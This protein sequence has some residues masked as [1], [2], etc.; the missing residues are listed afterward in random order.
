MLL[1]VW[2]C[3]AKSTADRCDYNQERKE[4][5]CIDICYLRKAC[6]ENTT[7][8]TVGFTTYC[9]CM[10]GF[11]GDP[12]LGCFKMDEKSPCSPDPCGSNANCIE[13]DL[14]IG[15]HCKCKTGFY[16]WPPNCREGCSSD[17]ECGQTEVCD[18]NN[19]CVELC[20][21]WRCGDNSICRVDKKK[22]TMH[23][24]CKDGYIPQ[25]EVGCRLKTEEDPDISIES[26]SEIL[27]DKCGGNCG[28]NA[29]CGPDDKCVCTDG[30]TGDPH[31][32]CNP[33]ST[34]FNGT[35]TP[36]PCGGYSTCKIVNKKPKCS[37]VNGYGT[38]PSCGKCN[39]NS[40]CDSFDVCT[41]DG[42][43]VFNACKPYCGENAGCNIFEGQ[44][45]CLCPVQAVNNYSLPFV[46]CPDVIDF[47]SAATIAVLSG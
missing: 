22:R 39:T 21:P 4:N 34:T 43:C 16:D 38:P 41:A 2:I 36:N 1:L 42:R 12:Q 32:Q 28:E 6:G 14:E 3:A 44:L 17:D 5:E 37:C 23:C 47:I 15:P 35:C 13:S 8:S 29:Y 19:L 24:S 26:F 10:K 33:I 30:Y 45:E 7:C 27:S 40:D 31:H 46:V 25:T 20:E 18:K 9:S 11:T